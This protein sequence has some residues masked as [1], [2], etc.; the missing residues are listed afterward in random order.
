[1][2]YQTN[3]TKQKITSVGELVENSEAHALLVEA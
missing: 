1:M 3:K 2:L